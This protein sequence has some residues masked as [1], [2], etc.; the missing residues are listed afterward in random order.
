MPDNDNGIKIQALGLDFRLS[1]KA[2]AWIFGIV[3]PSGIGTG[4]TFRG[5]I[6]AWFMTPAIEAKASEIQQTIIPAERIRTDS[7]IKKSISPLNRK[8][9]AIQAV[10]EEMPEGKRAATR[11]KERRDNRIF[12]NEDPE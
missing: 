8:M 11:L 3:L 4:L 9:S 10:L 1:K 6:I 5:P 12:E 7:V 2:L